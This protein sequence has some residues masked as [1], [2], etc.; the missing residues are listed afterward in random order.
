MNNDNDNEFDV[1]FQLLKTVLWEMGYKAT[2]KQAKNTCIKILSFKRETPFVVT[3]D[4]YY[5]PAEFHFEMQISIV[6]GRKESN[7]PAKYR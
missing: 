1:V 2:N 4:L 6:K 5:G 7:C 3:I